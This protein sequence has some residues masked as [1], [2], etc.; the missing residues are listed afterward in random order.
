MPD[1]N[2]DQFLAETGGNNFDP[3]KFLKETDPGAS[4]LESALQGINKGLTF[5][6]APKIYGAAKA[7]IGKI[8]GE[9]DFTDLY[10]KYVEA[11]REQE[12]GSQQKNPKT[13]L[14]GELGGGVAS[15]ANAVLPGGSLA[16]NV[17]GGMIAGGVMGAGDSDANISTYEGAKKYAGDVVRGAEY[18]AAGGTVGTALGAA[19]KAAP[20]LPKKIASVLLGAP[21]EAV[22]RYIKNPEAVKSA[23]SLTEAV[24]RVKN[25]IE[26][27]KDKVIAGSQGSRNILNE[28]G[29]EIERN[30]IADIAK[31]MADNI[32]NKMQGIND[33]PEK[34]AALKF[35][36]NIEK[37]W[38]GKPPSELSEKSLLVDQYGKNIIKEPIKEPLEPIKGERLKDTLQSLDK[39]TNWETSPGQFTPVDDRIKKELRSK[40]DD[41]L[42]NKSPEYGEQMKEV[43][44]DTDLLNRNSEMFRSDQGLSNLLNRV[45]RERAPFAEQ[46]LSDLDQRFGTDT[47]EQLKNSLAK[48]AFDKG[49]AGPGGSRNVNLYKE[50]MREW[51][52]RN[53]I[54]GGSAIGAGAGAVVDKYGPSIAKGGLDVY[55]GVTT[56]PTVASY[57]QAIS[58]GKKNLDD[59]PYETSINPAIIEYLREK[60]KKK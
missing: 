13:F 5:G 55:H 29:I 56:N 51:A 38:G 60:Q 26:N 37:E 28:Q 47:I 4:Y 41:Y 34:L 49:A 42:K 2:P 16:K 59:L 33:D 3:D 24:G 52:E 54:P 58:R 35:L 22:D 43:A 45:R 40:L 19:A 39:Q 11:Y 44:K 8:K 30:K 21:E 36:K 18:G 46:N 27:L 48:E 17:A 50:L 32:E 57:L 9:G 7:G 12:K 1:F 31:N 10:P 20:K 25:L 14:A 15:P 53:R 23:P 6:Q